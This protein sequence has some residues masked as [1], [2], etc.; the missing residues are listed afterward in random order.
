L[1]DDKTDFDAKEMMT[2]F[3]L[4]VIA[5]AGLGVEA[6]SFTEKNNI[7]R[8]KVTLEINHLDS[9]SFGYSSSNQIQDFFGC[10]YNF[11]T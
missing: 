8:Q 9:S 5:R 1:K 10:K 6:K 11:L 4:D 3:T 7:I 2:S